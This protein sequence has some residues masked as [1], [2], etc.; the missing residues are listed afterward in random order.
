MKTWVNVKTRPK[1]FIK[2]VHFYI[3][4][5]CIGLIGKLYC[6]WEIIQCNDSMQCISLL[7]SLHCTAPIMLN[8]VRCEQI[9]PLFTS[10]NLAMQHTMTP[11][12]YCAFVF[13]NLNAQKHTE[14]GFVL[15]MWVSC[16]RIPIWI[17]EIGLLLR[18]LMI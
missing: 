7:N 18:W 6:Y 8:C 1:K 5:P 13:D 4:F 17:Y 14:C 3:I 12:L 15:T 11:R 9:K 10:H 2:L 16:F